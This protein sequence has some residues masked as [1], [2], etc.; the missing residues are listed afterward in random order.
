MEGGALTPAQ[1]GK[2][3]SSAS[4]PAP[5][6]APGTAAQTEA[7]V[8][9]NQGGINNHQVETQLQTTASAVPGF[10]LQKAIKL[11]AWLSRSKR[12]TCGSEPRTRQ[13]DGLERPDGASEAE[14]PEVARTFE[15]QV[16]ES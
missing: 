9:W 6:G 12:A 7:A 13:A 4:D 1:G 10:L 2:R 8:T 11:T 5:R 16:T 14:R 15:S 3:N